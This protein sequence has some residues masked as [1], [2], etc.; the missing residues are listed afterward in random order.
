[1]LIAFEKVAPYLT[2]PL[3]LIGFVLLLVFGLY[4]ALIRSG[5]LQYI[6]KQA[7]G[8]TVQALLCSRFV[9]ALVVTVLGF[10]YQLYKT[11]VDAAPRVDVNA[12][13][14]KLEATHR[15]QLTRAQQDAEAWKQQAQA[16]VQALANLRSQKDAP[17]GINKA[18]A[19]LKQGNTK[20]AEEIF[21]VIANRRAASLAANSQAAAAAHRHLGALALL[22]DT[23]KALNA[24]RRATELDPD[25]AEGWHQL[26]SLFYRTGK[27]SQAAAAFRKVLPLGQARNDRSLLAVAYGN[28]GDIYQIRGDLKHAE[29]MYAKSLNIDKVLNNKGGMAKAYGNLGLIYETQEI[30]IRLRPCTVKRWYF[31]INL[32]RN[33]KALKCSD[34]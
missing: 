33:M 8:R 19:R 32:E 30:L 18:L 27:L 28:L 20:A 17:P 22:K 34:C 14:E 26:G 29:A 5:I 2:N 31:S 7:S 6:G 24:Y 10:G 9:L 11:H 12:I 23:Q 15:A 3:V 1:M 13:V 16:A 25:N 21:Q 4:Q